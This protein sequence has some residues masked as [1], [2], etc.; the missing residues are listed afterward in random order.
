MQHMTIV[1]KL[2]SIFQ[3]LLGCSI[4]SGFLNLIWF[5]L[6]Q[7][8]LCFC[9]SCPHWRN[10]MDLFIKIK[11]IYLFKCRRP[12]YCSGLLYT[13]DCYYYAYQAYI[14]FSLVGANFCTNQMKVNPMR[15]KEHVSMKHSVLLKNVLLMHKYGLQHLLVE[16]AA[17]IK[18]SQ[19][20]VHKIMK[21]QRYCSLLPSSWVATHKSSG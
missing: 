2:I 9:N 4:S 6:A 11:L 10:K 3:I 17:K 19:E 20:R 8:I 16:R 1:P 14:V 18:M 5:I 13:Q 12:N 7:I 15:G 21:S